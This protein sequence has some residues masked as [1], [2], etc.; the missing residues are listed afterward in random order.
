MVK[1]YK[2]LNKSMKKKVR[3]NIRDFESM[4][5]KNSKKIPKA[6]YAYLNCINF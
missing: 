4:L 1:E 2:S 3:E 6:V 5:A